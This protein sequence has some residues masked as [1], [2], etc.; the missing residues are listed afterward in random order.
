[1][2]FPGKAPGPYR[3]P[4]GFRKV[5]RHNAK[6]C[7]RRG[8]LQA[9]EVE[10]ERIFAHVARN[11][12][13]SGASHRE[14][15]EKQVYAGIITFRLPAR[16]LKAMRIRKKAAFP[17][18]TSNTNPPRNIADLPF[19][20]FPGCAAPHPFESVHQVPEVIG[21]AAGESFEDSRDV[22][23]ILGPFALVRGNGSFFP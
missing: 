7:R 16:A 19:Q 21:D 23:T 15:T 2:F 3:Y 10:F 13:E 4:K 8:E 6:G 9:V 14:G 1:M 20:S 5:R 18:E 12:L 22:L 11:D 17:E